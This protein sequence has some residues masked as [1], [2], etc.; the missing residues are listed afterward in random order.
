MRRA[1]VLLSEFERAW[2]S[3]GLGDSELEDL[4]DLLLEDPEAGDVI[5]G[6]GGARKVRIPLEGRGKSGGGRVIYVD[7]V[8]RERIYLITAY[9][10]NVQTDLDPDE[11]KAFRTLVEYIKKE[12]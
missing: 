2:K 4:Q 6:L 5:P 8:V 3:M 9:A 12:G 1:F 7:V 10:K 11:K